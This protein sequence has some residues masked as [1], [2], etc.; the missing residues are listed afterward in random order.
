MIA[1]YDP[2]GWTRG[3]TYYLIDFSDFDQVGN[4]KLVTNGISSHEFTVAHNLWKS[5]VSELIGFYRLQRCGCDT[6]AALPKSGFPNRPDKEAF[7]PAC[8]PD[9]AK[10]YESGVTVD[11]TGGWHDAG[12]N[13]KYGGNTGWIT[14][15]FALTFMRHPNATFDFD[16]NGVPDLLDEARVGAESLLKMMD[17]AGASGGIYDM[18]DAP[19]DQYYAW[20][21][22]TAET[23]GIRGN[24]DDRIGH[25]RNANAFTYDATM[26]TAGSLAAVA[27]AFERRDRVFANRCK[28]GAL[29]AYQWALANPQNMGGWYAIYDQ[30]SPRF[31]TE[32]QLYKLTKDQKY[33]QW[34]NNYIGGLTE[35]NQMP[36]TNYWGLEPIAL[37]EYYPAAPHSLR[38]KIVSL[39]ATNLNIWRQGLDQPFGTNYFGG[40]DGVG[41]NE[42][43]MSF[44][45][46]AYRLY[47]LTGDIHYR[48]AA[49]SAVQWTF[50]VNPWEMSWVSGVG[51]RYPGHLHS[52]LDAD[53][54]SNPASKIKLPGYMVF[55][56]I[57]SEPETSDGVHPWYE[58]RPLA[59]DKNNWMYNEF[60]ISIEYGLLDVV[61]ALAYDCK[62]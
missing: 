33:G 40:F 45:A 20:K 51:Y 18:I 61:V 39:L 26:K 3:E 17:G 58:D 21:Y 27:R 7:H 55:G 12:D 6:N 34:V 49:V 24:G 46:D 31:W 50:G 4:F 48:D 14:G 19:N 10:N 28:A 29:R 59:D 25:S 13:N 9:D 54:D 23:D 5:H 30:N 15:A 42:L 35:G 22:P 38:S 37:V 62:G 57:W 36:P 60:S 11:M 8:H 56:A 43:N 16:F 2:E 1:K 32:V 41:I 47:E 53:A 52:R 44:A